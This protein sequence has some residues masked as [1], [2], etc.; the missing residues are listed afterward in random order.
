MDFEFALA[1]PFQGRERSAAPAR[2]VMQGTP[3]LTAAARIRPSSVRALAAGRVDDERDR[4]VGE[5]VEQVRPAFVQFAHAIDRDA[6]GLKR[7][8]GPA[9]THEAITQLDELTRDRRDPFAIARGDADDD[10]SRHRQ[11]R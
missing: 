5:M 2:V 11:A 4:A 7:R 8:R 10:R 9:G 3:Q 6:F 1:K